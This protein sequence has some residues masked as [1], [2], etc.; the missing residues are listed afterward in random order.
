ML[1]F[2]IIVAFE[3]LGAGL[4]RLGVPLPGSVLGLIL[5]TLALMLGLVRLEW[6]ERS[7]LLLVRHMTLLFIPLMA[8]L[9]TM[10][11]ELR[12]NGV[13]LLASLGASLLAVLLTTGGLAHL[14]LRD[15]EIAEI[16]READ[17]LP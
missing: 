17:L 4:H 14:L 12:K 9:T 13:A 2:V 6:V 5:F 3:L 1:G 16:N 7:A 11:A 10:T 8:G 15:D